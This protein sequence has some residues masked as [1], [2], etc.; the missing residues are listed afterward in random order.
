[1]SRFTIKS[2][3]RQ[4][5]TEM[6]LVDEF[7]KFNKHWFTTPSNSFYRNKDIIIEY[8]KDYIN[9][10]RK[11]GNDYHNVDLIMVEHYFEEFL[12][13]YEEVA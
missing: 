3:Y 5:F 6:Q 9:N 8:L 2:E 1:M 13:L 4:K 10:D 12:N 7:V 11:W